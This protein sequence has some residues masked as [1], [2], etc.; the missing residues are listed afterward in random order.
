MTDNND[1]SQI[2]PDGF[3]TTL[4]RYVVGI[5]LGTTNCAVAYIDTTQASSTVAASSATTIA[6]ENFP[7]EQWVDLGASARRELLPSFLY[8]PQ[9]EELTS[10]SLGNA[11]SPLSLI[12]I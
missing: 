6:I 3:E 5:D 12:H 10:L 4:S 2:S 8:Q 11:T 1:P 7:L 9:A